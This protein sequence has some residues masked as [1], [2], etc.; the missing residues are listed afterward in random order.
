MFEIETDKL[1]AEYDAPYACVVNEILVKEG[2]VVE[3]GSVLAKVGVPGA[4]SEDLLMAGERRSDIITAI[5]YIQSL[6]P[7]KICLAGRERNFLRHKPFVVEAKSLAYAYAMTPI[8]PVGAQDENTVRECCFLISELLGMLHSYD[9]KALGFRALSEH[10]RIDRHI[11]THSEE[12]L[13]LFYRSINRVRL[14]AG[15]APIAAVLSLLDRPVSDS[16][17]RFDR[18]P[19]VTTFLVHGQNEG[20]RETVASFVE[21][22]TGSRPVVLHEMP[23]RG[24]TI[25]EKLERHAGAAQFAVILLTGDDEGRLRESDATLLPRARQN[26]VFELGFITG[27]LGRNRVAVLY[28][29]RTELPS[30][31]HGLVYVPVD[32]GHSWKR[33]L[34]MEMEAA[35]IPVDFTR[36]L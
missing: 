3:K 21:R 9:S 29:E 24:A 22:I 4:E 25:I 30:D 31:L 19:E 12:A 27:R 26:V 35:G 1:V 33:A 10:N 15:H 16:L 20:L 23:N 14:I 32:K 5:R 8:G 34:A 2:D 28:E 18:G 13:R 17:A 36:A 7:D 6:D 11:A